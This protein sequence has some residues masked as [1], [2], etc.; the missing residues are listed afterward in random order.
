MVN[1]VESVG[2]VVLA[3][4]LRINVPN[5]MVSLFFFVSFQEGMMTVLPFLKTTIISVF[6]L[7]I[8]GEMM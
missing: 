7:P 2:Q 6:R 1:A 8:K 5:S 4:F 3:V